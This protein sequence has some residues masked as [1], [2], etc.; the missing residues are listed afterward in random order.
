[1]FVPAARSPPLE[2]AVG[3]KRERSVG[4]VEDENNEDERDAVRYETEVCVLDEL[5]KV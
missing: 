2:D 4:P 3:K 1:M 5:V